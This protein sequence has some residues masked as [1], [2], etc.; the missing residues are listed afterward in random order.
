MGRNA[1]RTPFFFYL[2]SW[3]V[4]SILACALLVIPPEILLSRRVGYILVG[5][6][7]VNLVSA[8]KTMD[9]LDR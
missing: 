1:Y 7:F 2:I 6:A 3:L 9:L 4:I 8:L 5:A